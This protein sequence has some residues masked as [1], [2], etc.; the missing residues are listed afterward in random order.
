M[1][2]KL[3]Q[4]DLTDPDNPEWTEE[5]FARAVGPES[6]SPAELDAFPRTKVRGPQKTPTKKL[7][8]LRLTESHIDRF[9]VTG[10]GWQTRIDQALRDGDLHAPMA[11]L[12][13]SYGKQI[14]SLRVQLALLE[15]GRLATR[16]GGRDTTKESIAQVKASIATF[17]V[18]FSRYAPMV[19][20]ELQRSA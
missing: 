11:E 2:R 3:F 15:S 20:E 10:Q 16:S 12:L 5:D 7:I 14:D 8:S 4:P 9:K 18:L 13:R 6:L 1:S 19:A 17:E